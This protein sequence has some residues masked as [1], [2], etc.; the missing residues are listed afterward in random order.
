MSMQNKKLVSVLLLMAVVVTSTGILSVPQKAS[1]FALSSLL[2]GSS[3][4]VEG[5]GGQFDKVTQITVDTD[6]IGN[7]IIRSAVVAVMNDAFRYFSSKLI[8][9]LEAKIGVKNLLQYQAALVEGKYLVDSFRKSH[10]TY[11]APALAANNT[12]ALPGDILRVVQGFENL[13]L[14]T[15]LSSAQSSRLAIDQLRTLSPQL[16]QRYMEQL[17]VGGTALFTS[18]IICGGINNIA[19]NNTANYLAAASAGVLSSQIDPKSGVTFYEQMAR[20]GAPTSLP[21]FWTLQFQDNAAS[22]EAQA[23]QAASLELLSPGVKASQNRNPFTGN[24]DINRTVN[25]LTGSQNTSLASIYNAGLFRASNSIYPSNSFKDLVIY[26]AVKYSADYVSKFVAKFL[27]SILGSAVTS[28]AWFTAVKTYSGVIAATFTQVFVRN[29]YNQMVNLIFQGRILAESPSCR[30]GT[31]QTAFKNDF[32]PTNDS[33]TNSS[34]IVFQVNPLTIYLNDPDTAVEIIWD[35]TSAGSGATVT[36]GGGKFGTGQQ[37]AISGNTTDTPQTT[38]TY[39]LSVSGYQPISYTVTASP[40]PTSGSGG[41]GGSTDFSQVQF[42]VQPRSILV[43]ETVD[44]TWDASS[45]P[46]GTVNIF[47][48][49]GDLPGNPQ[50]LVGSQTYTVDTETTFRMNIFDTLS[51]QSNTRS[52]TITPGVVGGAFTSVGDWGG[53]PSFGV[54]E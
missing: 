49:S 2:P 21:Q 23:K 45:V 1:A 51:G 28:M 44:I 16:R 48:D 43:G 39:T 40:P 38:T 25:V 32:N 52:I 36:L 29:L 31:T 18:S 8:T 10:P 30:T 15:S 6:V 22:H 20:L 4:P 19:L 26:L 12:T 47:A 34:N 27:G 24:T 11:T 3:V 37:V 9:N 42:D 46:N 53:A 17:I 5:A 41:I 13:N 35:A 14:N 50:P 33:F 7:E 54:R